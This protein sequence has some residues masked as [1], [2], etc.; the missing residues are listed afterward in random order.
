LPIFVHCYLPITT[1]PVLALNTF[2]GSNITIAEMVEQYGPY[3]P[4]SEEGDFT[5]KNPAFQIGAGFS[6]F[7]SNNLEIHLEGVYTYNSFRYSGLQHGFALVNYKETHQKIEIPLSFTLDLGGEKWKPYLRLGASYGML[8]SA[9]IDYKRTYVNT[10]DVFYSPVQ[11]AGNNII[12]KRN[13]YSFSV[14]GGGGIKYKTGRGDLFFD[15]R[16]YYALSDMVNP[17]SRW[18]VESAFNYYYADSD[19][20]L[21]YFA[22]SLGFRYSLYRLKNL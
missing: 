10:G 16:Y 5:V 9:V 2:L 11:S 15:L 18:D 20:M 13:E 3:S 7:L 19:F 21:D 1:Y 14:V 12:E 17:D 6:T 4:D 22:F 8:L